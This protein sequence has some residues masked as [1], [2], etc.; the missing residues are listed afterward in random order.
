MKKR[1]FES[2]GEAI[3]TIASVGAA[4]GT[5]FLIGAKLGWW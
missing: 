2:R 3:R 1:W 4:A 5:F